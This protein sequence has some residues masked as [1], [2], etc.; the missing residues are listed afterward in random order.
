M[1]IYLPF[2][3]TS[4]TY[5]LL[6]PGALDPEGEV[7]SEVVPPLFLCVPPIYSILCIIFPYSE[8]L[9]VVVYIR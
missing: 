5:T 1:Y 6:P 3:M 4:I 8:S 7:M 9:S 2:V